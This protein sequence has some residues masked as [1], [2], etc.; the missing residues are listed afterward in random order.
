LPIEGNQVLKKARIDH[1]GNIICLV[2]DT[3]YKVGKFNRL[4]KLWVLKDLIKEDKETKASELDVMAK[5]RYY[6]NFVMSKD[7]KSLLIV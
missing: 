5:T 1:K 3:I 4:E 7:R 6:D 2:D